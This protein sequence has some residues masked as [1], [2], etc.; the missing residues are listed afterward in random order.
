MINTHQL[1]G[2][3]LS[4]KTENV[5]DH[6]DAFYAWLA[7]T[8]VSAHRNNVTLALAEKCDIFIPGIYDASLYAE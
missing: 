2:K 7:D 8:G 1:I 4:L 3:F 5:Q 6:M